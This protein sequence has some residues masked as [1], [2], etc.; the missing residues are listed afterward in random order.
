MINLRILVRAPQQQRQNPLKK[1]VKRLRRRTAE[2]SRGTR[3]AAQV[4]SSRG[5][6]IAAAYALVA[7]LAFFAACNSAQPRVGDPAKCNSSAQPMQARVMLFLCWRSCDVR[8]SPRR[9]LG[10]SSRQMLNFICVCVCVREREREG[11]ERYRQMWQPPYSSE[12]RGGPRQRQ[13]YL[14]DPQGSG[15]QG[16]PRSSSD[17]QPIWKYNILEILP[18]RDQ[19]F[20][21]VHHL[22]TMQKESMSSN[23]MY[24]LNS[25]VSGGVPYLP[26]GP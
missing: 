21:M 2:P 7:S 19:R 10:V 17:L 13:A 24:V 15:R 4:D 9:L 20:V 3:W 8:S 1:A 6:V 16:L 14:L 5:S 22:K 11:G 25:T 18:K 26:L 23:V 12:V